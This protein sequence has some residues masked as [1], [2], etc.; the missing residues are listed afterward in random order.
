M[1]D[2]IIKIDLSELV[3][4]PKTDSISGRSFGEG[5]AE[6]MKI[7]EQ[8]DKKSKIHIVIDNSKIKAINDSFWKGFFSKIFEKYKSKEKVMGFFEFETNSFFKEH[9]NKNLTIL[10]SIYNV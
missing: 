4:P 6:K 10:D 2:Q 3:D 8:L 1:N 9:I 5:Y 7:I